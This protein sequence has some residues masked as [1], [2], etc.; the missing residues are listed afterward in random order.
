MSNNETLL[1]RFKAT[2]TITFSTETYA[3]LQ[4]TNLGYSRVV[5]TRT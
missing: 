1:K 3:F 5:C 2:F 4:Q